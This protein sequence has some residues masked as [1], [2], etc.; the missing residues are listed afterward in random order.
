MG[1]TT[2]VF[3]QHIS[4]FLGSTGNLPVPPGHWPGGR[5]NPAF[6]KP[7]VSRLQSVILGSGRRVSG[8]V[9]SMSPVRELLSR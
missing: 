4:W 7:A 8:R 6:G 2:S 1:R 9:P 5:S 3:S